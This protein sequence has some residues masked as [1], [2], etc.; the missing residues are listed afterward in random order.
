MPI[1]MN[2]VGRIRWASDTHIARI[3]PI[4]SLRGQRL[5]YQPIQRSCVHEFV[6]V[7]YDSGSIPTIEG[8]QPADVQHSHLQSTL[9]V[10]C[11]LDNVIIRKNERIIKIRILLKR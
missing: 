4:A 9:A 1:I 5:G 2:K 10:R 8:V 3:R 6:S 7:Q 11:R